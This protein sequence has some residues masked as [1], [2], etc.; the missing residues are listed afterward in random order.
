ML[1]IKQMTQI[2]QLA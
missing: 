2:L 1:Q